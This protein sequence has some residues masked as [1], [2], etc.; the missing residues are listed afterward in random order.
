MTKIYKQSKLKN[1]NDNFCIEMLEIRLRVVLKNVYF[2]STTVR[3]AK[4]LINNGCIKVNSVTGNNCDYILKHR[5]FLSVNHDYRKTAEVK[6]KTQITGIRGLVTPRMKKY[7]TIF[8]RKNATFTNLQAGELER[9]RRSRMSPYLPAGKAIKN[10]LTTR[11]APE[12]Y[13]PEVFY[14]PTSKDSRSIY[15]YW[16]VQPAIYYPDIG[17]FPRHG[18]GDFTYVLDN[19]SVVTAR[20]CNM[21]V[22]VS[23]IHLTNNTGYTKHNFY[24]FP[25]TIRWVNINRFCNKATAADGFYDSAKNQRTVIFN[26]RNLTDSECHFIKE[27]DKGLANVDM[28]R[29]EILTNHHRLLKIGRSNVPREG[30]NLI[31]NESLYLVEYDTHDSQGRNFKNR[32]FTRYK[33][34]KRSK[35]IWS[36]NSCL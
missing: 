15:S 5:N 20:Y 6:I 4:Q 19:A 27:F 35:S 16:K 30:H 9:F 29:S 22:W 12:F 2:C 7:Q 10:I 8:V 33:P 28:I 3:E 23:K 11:L 25:T 26:S 36:R 18:V 17:G 24:D 32:F 14:R 34:L 13:I 1:N 31:A 21:C